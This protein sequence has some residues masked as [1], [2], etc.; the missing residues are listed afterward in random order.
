MYNR[1]KYLLSE[2]GAAE[3]Q[4]MASRLRTVAEKKKP[5]RASAKTPRTKKPMTSFEQQL[6]MGELLW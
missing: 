6:F 4:G 2:R 3:P 5:G 1:I